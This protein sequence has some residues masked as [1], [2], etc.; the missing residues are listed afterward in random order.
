M[1]FLTILSI[2]ALFMALSIKA[3][4]IEEVAEVQLKQSEV[5]HDSAMVI[6]KELH[7]HND[8][9]LTKHFGE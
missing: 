7:E 3:K 4:T 8:S 5:L 2:V 6:L 9:L 1:K